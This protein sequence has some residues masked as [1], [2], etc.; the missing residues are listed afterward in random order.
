MANIKELPFIEQ[1]KLAQSES[2]SEAILIELYHIIRDNI[3]NILVGSSEKEIAQLLASNPNTPVKIL[4]ELSQSYYEEIVDNPVFE[5]LL[6]ENSDRRF[7]K[8]C[9]AKSTKTSAE[10]LDKLSGESSLE[11]CREVARNN[12]TPADEFIKLANKRAEHHDFSVR[13]TIASNSKTPVDI[14]ASLAQDSDFNVRRAVASN[15]NTPVIVLEKLLHDARQSV[16]QAST[17]NLKNISNN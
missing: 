10:T 6:L 8:L 3:Y 4:E 14:L 1:K 5:L 2:T 13:S 9:L 15:P 17:K 11:I 7:L 12:N 16:R